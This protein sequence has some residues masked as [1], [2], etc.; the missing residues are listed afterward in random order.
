MD[1][2]SLRETRKVTGTTLTDERKRTHLESILKG[3]DKENA[4]FPSGVD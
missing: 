4:T 1:N 2:V 3:G